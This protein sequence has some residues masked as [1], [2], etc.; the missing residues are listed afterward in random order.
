MK[1][2]LTWEQVVNEHGERCMKFL[3]AQN[4]EPLTTLPLAYR[5]SSATIDVD[6]EMD[7]V[8]IR[9]DDQ[10]FILRVGQVYSVPYAKGVQ[11]AVK[12]AGK[13]LGKVRTTIKKLEKKWCGRTVQFVV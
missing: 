13:N 5:E 6:D 8:V 4:I 12:A 1:V 7:A 2:T 9:R 3:G 10:K 11:K